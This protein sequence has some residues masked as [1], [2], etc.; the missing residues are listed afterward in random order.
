MAFSFTVNINDQ[1]NEGSATDG[2]LAYD[3]TQ[4]LNIWSQYI[5]GT[6]TLVVQLNIGS[7]STQG[8]ADGGPTSSAD[9]GKSSNG[10]EIWD[11]SSHYELT[12]GQHVSGT[13]SDIYV[14]V[15]SGYMQQWWDIS[16]DCTYNSQVPSG[17]YNPVMVFL[18]EVMHGLGQSG[19]YSSNGTLPGSYES[20]FDTFIQQSASGSAYFTGKNA[21]AVYGGPVPLTTSSTSGEN[22]YHFGNTQS[23]YYATPSTVQDPLTLDL[24]NGVV[25]FP[26]YQYKISNLDLA[27]LMDLGYDVA[28]FATGVTVSGGSGSLSAGKT[29]T[30]TVDFIHA[31]DVTGVPELSLNDGGTATYSSGSGGTALN[32]AY[33]VGAHDSNV[34]SLAVTG[35]VLDGGNIQDANG[36]AADMSLA[37]VTQNG[38]QVV[39]QAP[40]STASAAIAAYTAGQLA[41]PTAVADSAADVASN[42]DGLGNLAAA[43]KLGAITLTDSGTPTLTLSA[44][45]TVSDASVLKDISGSFLLSVAASAPDATVDGVSGHG[46][47]AVFSG[48]ADQ[49]AI[50]PTGDGV[51]FTLT[52]TGSGGTSVDHVSDVTALQFSDG[53]D[54]VAHQNPAGSTAVSTFMITALYGAVFAR[55]PDVAGLAYYQA[56]EAAHPS[57]PYLQFAQWF[58]ASP[59]YTK[60]HSYT[61]TAAGDAQ[62]ITDSYNNLLHRAPSGS[63]VAWY[64]ANVIDP[65]LAAYSPG[66]T[67]YAQADTQAHAQVLAYFANSSEFQNDVQITAQ[68]PADAQHWLVLV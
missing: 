46:T 24:M 22:Y 20:T 2:V 10:L 8:R 56:Y 29:V 36:V 48:P 27:V 11:P 1:A 58:L 65:M 43:G 67:A 37:N 38:P 28:D 32:F 66:A 63:D 31:A 44:A 4:A 19:W 41:S 26:G 45:Q 42:L 54:F 12:T 17:E 57:T 61:A 14:D 13:T 35:I 68:H 16:Q 30:I 15:D 50:T 52:S 55:T 5:S 60:A 33:T 25:F 6:G 53:T 47:T 9:T 62:F 7:A 64:Q 59:E 18:H 40:I 39:A 23:D 3:L 34:A 51:S 49:Y 21:E